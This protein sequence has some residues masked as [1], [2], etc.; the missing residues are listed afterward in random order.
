MLNLKR[1][2][3]TGGIASGKSLVCEYFAKCGA[4]VVDADAIVSHLLSPH[5]ILGRQIIELLGIECVEEERFNRQKIAQALFRNP[6]LLRQYEALIH[7]K[8]FEEIEK[9]YLSA[10]KMKAPLFVAEV[11]LLFETGAEVL[12]DLSIVV[13][14]PKE[15]R[16]ARKML[17]Y[18]EEREARQLTLSEKEAKAAIVLYNLGSKEELFAQV[19]TLFN[20]LTEQ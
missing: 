11:P 20:Q 5:T 16:K 14:A 15:I 19:T 8:V 3:V 2:A 18:F 4:F 7:P 6:R 10:L 17:S 9:A 12:F 1:V 13:T